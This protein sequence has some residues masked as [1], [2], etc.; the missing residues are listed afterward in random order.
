MYLEDLDQEVLQS[1]CKNLD[2]TEDEL[3]EKVTTHH[4]ELVILGGNLV[5]EAFILFGEKRKEA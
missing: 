2:M 3:H 1:L 5:H 4:A